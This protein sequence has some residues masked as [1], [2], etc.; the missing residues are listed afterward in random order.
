MFSQQ[1]PLRDILTK[2]SGLLF[3]TPFLSGRLA[4]ADLV[5]RHRIGAMR[6]YV[7]GLIKGVDFCAFRHTLATGFD[8]KDGL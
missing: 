5:G 2:P 1:P 4:R 7:V 6:L 3:F 8:S